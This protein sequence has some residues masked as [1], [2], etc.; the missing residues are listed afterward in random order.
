MLDTIADF[1][2]PVKK[3][4]TLA[5]LRPEELQIGSEIVFGFVPQATLSGKR[6]TVSSI[7]S[8]QF[9]SDILTSFVLTQEKDAGA[10]MI[11]AEADG[12][13]YLAI[14]R[15]MSMGDRGKLFNQD[16]L[17]AVISQPDVNAISSK[18]GVTDYKGWVVT[19]Y[20][21]EIAGMK[22]ALFSGDYRK[23]DAPE[24]GGQ[25]FTYTL[26]VSDTN[27]HALEIEKY[28]DGRIEVYATVYRRISDIGEISH[29]ATAPAVKSVKLE[30]QSSS[31]T[32]VPFK[33]NTPISPSL[34]SKEVVM[35]SESKPAPKLEDS[36]KPQAAEP[37]FKP[38]RPEPKFE[39]PTPPKQ[40]FK[41]APAP[42]PAATSTPI[43]AP[44]PKPEVKAETLKP[45]PKAEAPK[46]EEKHDIV[47]HAKSE[48]VKL[49][50]FNA[51]DVAKKEIEEPAQPIKVV[52]QGEAV[53]PTP[54]TIAVKTTQQP[55]THQEIKTVTQEATQF[56]NESIDCDLPV[57]NKIIDEAIRQEMRINDVVRRVIGLPVSAQES[58]QIPVTLTDQDY[59]LLAIRYGIS[60][61][62]RDAIKKRIIEDLSDFSGVN[63]A[64]KAA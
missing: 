18:E 3:F 62:D 11:V 46:A 6:L 45:E 40:E 54:K 47:E 33:P 26:L 21:R 1:W 13:K 59:S 39:V 34:S 8:Y 55:F 51:A 57:A 31:E 60:A 23:V 12:E 32:V 24:E 5:K 35:K 28:N 19:H 10:S 7:N 27:E 58:V 56:V 2:K 38:I 9:G 41:P 64:R 44:A 52:S 17:E 43:P 25:P 61:N 16:E 50:E 30:S 63:K 48:P 49:P 22:G 15:R 37:A 53:L 4:P 42:V 29:P 20:K 14:S 36:S